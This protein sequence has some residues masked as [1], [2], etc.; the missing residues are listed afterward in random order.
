M[1]ITDTGDWVPVERLFALSTPSKR[2]DIRYNILSGLLR[3]RRIMA[4]VQVDKL[5]LLYTSLG[6][7]TRY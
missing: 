4:E 3:G 1:W 5:L 7:R 2:G 6:G